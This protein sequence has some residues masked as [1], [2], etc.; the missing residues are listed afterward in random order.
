M[1]AQPRK[2]PNVG[3]ERGRWGEEIAAAAL[4]R[5]GLEIVE[6]NSRPCKRDRRLEIDIIAYDRISDVMVFVEVKQHSARS[7][8]QRRLRSVD[9]RKLGNLRRACNAWKWKNRYQGC[10]RFDV[11]EIY[12]EPG[13][14]EPVVDHIE[15]VCLF[16]R[17]DR[18]VRWTDRE[19]G[20]EK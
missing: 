12:G 8:W 20:G 4:R 17:P 3:V 15:R 14:G 18:F 7:E 9:K 13:R 6:R 16:G 11:V 10:F 1:P 5:S 19:E 2:K